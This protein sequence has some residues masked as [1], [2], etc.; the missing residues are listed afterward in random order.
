MVDTVAP[1]THS[2]AVL[3]SFKVSAW[4]A[5]PE[6]IPVVRRLAVPEPGMCSPLVEPTLLQYKVL[7]HL[8]EVRDFSNA[9]KPWFLGSSS[10]SSQSG[11]PDAGDRPDGGG[12]VPFARRFWQFGVPDGRRASGGGGQ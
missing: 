12:V 4:T 10:S 5:N 3:S 6:A 1:E 2:R 9:G 8:D 7:I 11:I